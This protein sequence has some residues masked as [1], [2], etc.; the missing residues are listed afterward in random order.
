MLDPVD[1]PSHARRTRWPEWVLK[2]GEDDE[3]ISDGPITPGVPAYEYQED[4]YRPYLL[5]PLL[6]AQG[7]LAA[8]NCSASVIGDTNDYPNPSPALLSG[9]VAHVICVG[10]ADLDFRKWNLTNDRSLIGATKAELRTKLGW[11][12][13]ESNQNEWDSHGVE[14]ISRVF[15]HS[16]RLNACKEIHK[17]LTALT[18]KVSTPPSSASNSSSKPSFPV[19][20]KYG[21]FDSVWAGTH[22]HVGFNAENPADIS[23]PFLQHLVF[24][25]LVNEPLI[26][27]LHPKYRSGIG[28]DEFSTRSR[29]RKTSPKNT[30]P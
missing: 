2:V 15:A 13:N 19:D 23:L 4:L 26:S 30:T 12:V 29:R 24:I 16:D 25:L 9:Q 3:C 27:K 11:L 5:E 8:A 28:N 22:V 7:A 1:F 10:R 14:L 17:Y 18:H 21:A 6:I 20:A